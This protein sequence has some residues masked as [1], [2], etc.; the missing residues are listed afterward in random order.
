MR[1]D[2]AAWEGDPFSDDDP[3]GTKCV[4]TIRRGRRT[5]G[6]VEIEPWVPT[7]E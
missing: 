5:H 1:A 3:R 2:L 6:A 7:S 4:L